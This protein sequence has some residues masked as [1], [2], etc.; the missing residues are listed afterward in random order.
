MLFD[1]PRSERAKVLS[2]GTVAGA[3]VLGVMEVCAT[4]GWGLMPL[5]S[6]A[7]RKRGTMLVASLRDGG[8]S[9]DFFI[10]R[11]A[12]VRPEKASFVILPRLTSGLSGSRV[13]P[14]PS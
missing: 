10:S 1:V 12:R 6:A 13:S 2:K 8:A 9:F 3:T 11:T 7:R 14:Q 5:L 4:A